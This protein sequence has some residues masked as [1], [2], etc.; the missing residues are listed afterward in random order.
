MFAH[1]LFYLIDR[2]DPIRCYQSGTEWTWEQGQWRW[3]LHSQNLR[4]SSLAIRWSN[5][6]SRTLIGVEF[7]SIQRCSRCI[8]CPYMTEQVKL[9]MGLT[10]FL[11]LLCD[12]SPLSYQAPFYRQPSLI[13]CKVCVWEGAGDRTETAIFWPH[14]Y[15]RQRCVFLVLLM[16]NQKPRGPLCWVMAFFA[17]SYQ[18]L[19]W[20]PN[21]IVVPE[22]PFDRVWL[23]LPHLVHNSVRSVTAWLLSWLSYIIVQ[24]P[25]SHLLDLWNRMFDLHQAEITIIQFTGHSLPVHQ[26]MSVPW[27]FFYLVPFHQPISAHAISS[28]KYH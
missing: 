5:I 25:L 3:T 20:S 14:S 8:L 21:S 27:E 18:Q 19:L 10:S 24:R 22:G 9:L 13:Y 1:S 28:H 6:I 11:N 26:S 2:E 23:S 15:G 12:I 7:Y 16:L 4:G 17:A